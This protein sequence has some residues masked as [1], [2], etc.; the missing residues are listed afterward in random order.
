MDTEY[1]GIAA[2]PSP[3]SALLVFGK[4]ETESVSRTI[5]RVLGALGEEGKR[6]LLFHICKRF[7]FNV[8]DI[9]HNP[10][11][12]GQ[13]LA[14]ILG[15]GAEVIELAM[16]KQIL[17]SRDSRGEEREYVEKMASATQAELL[18]LS[19]QSGWLTS[20]GLH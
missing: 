1:A 13:A 11:K 9:P 15:G 17:S 14:S 6:A 4:G 12:F 20:I 16:V 7:N 8:G 5:D 3:T 18:I 2:H 10:E 19:V